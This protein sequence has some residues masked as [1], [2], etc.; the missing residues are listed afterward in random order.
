MLNIASKSSRDGISEVI[1]N[2]NY[3]ASSPAKKIFPKLKRINRKCAKSKLCQTTTIKSYFSP[4][5]TAT[6]EKTEQDHMTN[7]QY[8]SQ[9]EDSEGISDHPKD[10]TKFRQ[11]D[12]VRRE[13]NTTEEVPKNKLTELDL[14]Y[15]TKPV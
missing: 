12:P 9:S 15:G 14:L 10:A 5:R 2:I 8:Y 1:E 13:N 11:L 3:K 6:N 4:R 7:I